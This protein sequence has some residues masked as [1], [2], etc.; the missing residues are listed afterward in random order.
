MKYLFPFLLILL[1]FSSF[2]QKAYQ[3]QEKTISQNEQVLPMPF[4]GGINSAQVQSMDLNGNGV[5]ELVIWDINSRSIKVFEQN[6]GQYHELPYMHHFFPA[7]VSGFLVLA[8]FDGDG[9]KDLFT[10][11][12]FG[13]KAYKNMSDNGD[14]T[15]TWEVA[16]TFLKLENGTNFQANNLDVPAIQDIDGDGDLDIVTFNFASGDYLEFYKNT[17]VERTGTANIDGFASP[18]IRWGNFEFCGCGTF[19]FGQTCDGNPI[20][21]KLPENENNAIQHSGGHAIL[22]RDF[23]GDGVLDMVMGQD[24]CNTLY[25]LENQ[26]SNTAPIF[27]EF[28]TS[29]PG[30]GAFPQFPIFHVPQILDNQLLI[31]SNSSETSLTVGIDFSK[32]LYLKNPTSNS[33]LVTIAFLQ[34]DMIDLG[35]NSRPFFKGNASSGTLIV[36]ANTIQE[37]SAVGQAFR[38]VWNGESLEWAEADYLNLSNLGLTEL[39]YLEYT[40]S[41]NDNYLFVSGVEIVDFVLSRSLFFSNTLDANNLQLVSIPNVT[42]R[43]N[44]HFEFYQNEGEDYLLLARQTGELQRYLVTFEDNMPQFKLLNNDYLGFTDNPSSRNLVV[45]TANSNGQL[46]LYAIDQRGILSYISDFPASSGNTNT[47]LL[48]FPDGRVQSTKLGR[49]TWIATAPEAFGSKVHLVLGN[50]AGGLQYLEEITNGTN[51]PVEGE[52]QVNV[53]PN[54]TN[55]PLKVIANE[56][57]QAR[58]INSMG[59]I[60]VNEFDITANTIQEMDLHNLSPGLYFVD[61]VS[62]SGKRMTKKLIVQ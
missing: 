13:I 9:K 2:A 39:Q 46:D 24:E 59:Q 45:K 10:S 18:V 7:D 27:N 23:N 34:E 33:S 26:G 37:G 11:T 53:Y 62:D 61:F 41:E 31:S 51:P 20:S 49:N 36:T 16:E 30:Y 4:A 28:T 43:S 32:S 17:S 57:G 56:A 14:S 44:D 42:L 54:P 5:E 35:E 3:Y 12:A 60:L 50:R 52:L 55:G 8:D 58:L 21:R 1:H 29:L 38:Y 48:A 19:S 40:S 25:Y 22:L 47:D 6:S 15:P